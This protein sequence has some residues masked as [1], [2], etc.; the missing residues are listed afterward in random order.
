MRGEAATRDADAGGL[1]RA[2]AGSGETKRETAEA[3][4]AVAEE[5]R[6]GTSG[7]LLVT[8]VKPTPEPK[9]L[10]GLAGGSSSLLGLC[11]GGGDKGKQN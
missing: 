2:E 7:R 6:G 9:R 8:G 5:E 10:T 1:R 3:A 4:A 11:E